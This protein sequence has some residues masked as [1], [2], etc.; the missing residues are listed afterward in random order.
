MI[1][2]KKTAVLLFLGLSLITQVTAQSNDSVISKLARYVSIV[3][4]FSKNLPQ[5]KAY[6]HFDNSTYYQGDDMWFS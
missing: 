1:A 3:D 4:H 6:L 2:T 5:E